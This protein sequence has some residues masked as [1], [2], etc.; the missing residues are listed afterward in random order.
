M[1]RPGRPG[2][3]VVRGRRL[4]D[5][6]AASMFNCIATTTLEASLVPIWYP[7]FITNRSPKDVCHLNGLALDQGRLRYATV[8]AQRQDEGAWR[9]GRAEGAVIE[10]ASDTPYVTGLAQPH[11]PRLYDGRSMAA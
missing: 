7:K 4:I 8:F 10:V 3:L 2:Y 6:V 11:S 1:L 5:Q 9:E